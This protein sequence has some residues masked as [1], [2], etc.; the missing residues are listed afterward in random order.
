[1]VSE[2]EDKGMG[3]L[4]LKKAD[5]INESAFDKTQKALEIFGQLTYQNQ[6]VFLEK[7]QELAIAQAPCPFPVDQV[8]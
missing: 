4:T 3:T 2:R 8:C 1:M 7:L 6:I 5:Q